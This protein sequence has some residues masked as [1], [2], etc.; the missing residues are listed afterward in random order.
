MTETLLVL[1][2]VHIASVI[3]ALGT[4]LTFPLWVRAGERDPAHLPFVLRRVRL[5]DR[6]VAI[7]GYALAALSGLALALVGGIPLTSLWLSLSIAIYVL[8]ALLGFGAYR[9][10]SRARLA[11]LER[12]GPADPAY[13]AARGRARM[14]DA[15]VIGGVLAILGLMVAKP[16]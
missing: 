5:L 4:N 16:L 8:I 15:V 2:L 7:P 1:R 11:A 13:L 10:V 12:G 14:L 3:L 6:F 9:P